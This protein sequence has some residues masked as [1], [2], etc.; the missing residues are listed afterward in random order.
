MKKI[1][2]SFAIACLFTACGNDNMKRVMV[3][4][5]GQANIDKEAKTITVSSG[6][7]SEE[8]TA[9]FTEDQVTLQLSTQAGKAT[10]ELTEPG[11]YVINAKTDTI[12]GSYQR[13]G[14]P[15]TETKTYTQ[16]FIKSQIDSLQ[17]L[18]ENKNVNAANRNF[19]IAPNQAVKISNNTDAFIVGPFHKMTSIKKEGD[20]EP[21]VYRFYMASEIRET[22]EHLQALTTAP[23]AADQ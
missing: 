10:V 17:Q 14:A 12:V 13:Y 19:F 7:S 15:A 1:F 18:L 16:D 22:I 4:S 9:D 21:E 8:Q 11:Y 2:L 6:T 3:F 20:K 23:P 5:R